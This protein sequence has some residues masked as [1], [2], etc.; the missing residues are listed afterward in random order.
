VATREED[1]QITEHACLLLDKH[2]L[3]APENIFG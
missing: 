1:F 2:F 3:F